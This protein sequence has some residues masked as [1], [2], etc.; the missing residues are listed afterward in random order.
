MK[1]NTIGCD[2]IWPVILLSRRSGSDR[3]MSLRISIPWHCAQGHT[4]IV[5]YC[6]CD[7]Q[8]ALRLGAVTFDCKSCGEAYTVDQDAAEF[9]GLLLDAIVSGSETKA[10]PKAHRAPTRDS[11]LPAPEV[12]LHQLAFLESA[13]PL[14]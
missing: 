3:D 5:T 14:T 8:A 13:A 10:P 7:L 11:D 6:I 2:I 4:I 1:K 12:T 9:L